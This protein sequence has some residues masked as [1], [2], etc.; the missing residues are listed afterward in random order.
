MAFISFN[1]LIFSADTSQFSLGFFQTAK[2]KFTF[3]KVVEKTYCE[4]KL[5][6]A[7][8]NLMLCLPDERVISPGEAAHRTTHF[9]RELKKRE[10]PMKSKNLT[11]SSMQHSDAKHRTM[12]TNI[13]I[14]SIFVSKIPHLLTKPL[15]MIT[16][17][18]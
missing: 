9:I 8:S 1:L 4:S 11:T 12:L 17:N 18:L 2:T 14:C 6:V 10:P 13:G 7:S 5:T 3:Y 15:R 16:S